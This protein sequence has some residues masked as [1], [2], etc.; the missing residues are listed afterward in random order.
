M[1]SLFSPTTGFS[2]FFS[3]T[4]SGAEHIH[5]LPA[6]SLNISSSLLPYDLLF[7][8]P[9][10]VHFSGYFQ[11]ESAIRAMSFSSSRGTFIWKIDELV[12]LTVDNSD[13]Q[14]FSTI[15]I[16]LSPG[17]HRIECDI[18]DLSP[19]PVFSVN[20]TETIDQHFELLQG[21]F[22]PNIDFFSLR[23]LFFLPFFKNLSLLL[24]F[25]FFIPLLNYCI[26]L[27]F[28]A[29]SRYKI[30]IKSLSF[31]LLILSFFYIL[32]SFQRY[33][34]HLYEA[35]EAAFGLMGQSLSTGQSPPLF[36]YGQDYQGTLEAFPLSLL[37][38]LFDSP[39]QALH[40]LPTLFFLFFLIFT[41][42]AYSFFGGFLLGLFSFFLLCFGGL[43]FYWIF[44]KTWFGYSFSLCMGAFILLITFF[45]Y[46]KGHF[47]VL[48]CFLLGALCGILFYVLPISLPFI[49]CC[50]I[51]VFYSFYRQYNR[52]FLFIRFTLAFIGSFF[53]FCFP[54][55]FS[56]VEKNDFGVVQFLFQERD[57]TPPRLLGE[58]PFLHRFLGECLP[59][60]FG[61]RAPYDQFTNFPGIF[62]PFFAPIL[63]ILSM[64]VFP[65]YSHRFLSSRSLFRNNVIRCSLYLFSLSSIL[66]VF[67]SEKGIWPWY[68]IPLYWALPL[69]FFVLFQWIY[70]FSPALFFGSF[71]ILFFSLFSTFFKIS[72]FLFQPASLS[73]SCLPL[74]PDFN[75]AEELFSD[76]NIRYV[77]CD[78]G[79]DTS[80]NVSGRDWIGECLT[81]H[82]NFNRIAND[83]ILRR[84]PSLSMELMRSNHVAYLFHKHYYYNFP[85]NDF[86]NYIPL[87]IG[88]LD[89][90]FSSDFLD[91]EK[92]ENGAFNIYLPKKFFSPVRK[93]LWRLSSSNPFFLNASSDH[94]IS[95]RAYGS[96]GY[97][98]SDVI[99]DLGT[100]FSIT[101]NKTT[102]ISKIILFHGTKR[103]DYPRENNVVSVNEEGE[104]VYIGKLTYDIESRSSILLLDEPVF[105]KEL[106]IT[107]YPVKGD[108]W[109]TIFEIWIL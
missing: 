5:F 41:V 87:S 75:S 1:F 56:I 101:M 23:F 10:T 52:S 3:D 22:Y 26:D 109:L 32:F 29:L 58:N 84:L 70:S 2:V 33:T 18:S 37:L 45:Y 92:Y 85:E 88:N 50:F 36:H 79:Y 77:I 54:Y 15:K 106:L 80:L 59:T 6:D 97:W 20:V 103:Y 13:I 21:P 14:R 28:S 83:R 61:M 63:F 60:F 4:E 93:D 99:P 65:L 62:C 16:D 74:P 42:S 38:P 57:L 24:S 47:S 105:S 67:F 31:P 9:S 102:Q 108:F 25:F 17:I 72:P 95:V 43:H 64:I 39:A 71:L 44:S 107:V 104:H 30:F 82:S 68:F 91:Y 7:D 66:F 76:N 100:R 51:L 96:D 73:F 12:V 89:R 78:Q 48:S 94:N 34:N 81:Y 8:P 35:D 90:L 49:L 40:S 98:S 69:L 46:Q 27:S 86:S 19:F 11:L 55:W 53:L